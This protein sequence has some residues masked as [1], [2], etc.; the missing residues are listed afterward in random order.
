M[1]FITFLIATLTFSTLFSQE[2]NPKILEEV[3]EKGMGFTTPLKNGKIES[4]KKVNPPKDTWLFSKL[5]EYKQNIGSENIIYGSI[6]MPNPEGTFYSYNL[7]AYDTNREFYYFVAI[8]SYEPNGDSAKFSNSYL[9]TEKRGLKDW[10]KKTFSYYQ[11]DIIKKIP[12]KYLF[13]T[14]PPPPFKPE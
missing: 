1:R 12:K 11:S 9:F 4:L 10:W 2:I 14:C 6:I 5:E 8:A 13:E 3:Y 7:F